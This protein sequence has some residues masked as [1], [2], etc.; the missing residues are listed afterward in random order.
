MRDDGRP[1]DACL[2]C[3]QPVTIDAP[4]LTHPSCTPTLGDE[5]LA[6]IAWSTRTMP[7]SMQKRIGPSGIGHPC[8]RWIG[9]TI[10]GFEPERPEPPTGVAGAPWKPFV[11]TAVHALLAERFERLELMLQAASGGQFGTRFFMEHKVSSGQTIG[12]ETIDGTGDLFD[13]WT[14]TVIDWKVTGDNMRRIYRSKGPGWQYRTQ[15][16]EY[17]RGWAA[18]GHGVDQV[19]IVFLPMAGDLAD[20]VIWHEPFWP[21]LA[22]R[23]YGRIDRL[24]PWVTHP[25]ESVRL[26]VLEELAPADHYCGNCP[27]HNKDSR[28]IREGCPG[29]WKAE[30]RRTAINDEDIMTPLPNGSAG[31]ITE[32][33]GVVA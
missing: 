23:A 29:Y 9:M 1:L 14:G 26:Q 16:H 27:F 22:E 8:E 10:A 25:D 31:T 15:V 20:S 24:Y 12:P 32:K 19:M 4:V 21:E 28:S 33:E 18:A 13:S 2:V 7:R 3:G 6:M 30:A 5:L 17:G 11:G